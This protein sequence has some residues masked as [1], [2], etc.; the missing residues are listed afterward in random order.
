MC[1]TRRVGIFDAIRAAFVSVGPEL[2]LT[3]LPT[4]S[5]GASS[6]HLFWRLPP[7][8]D[9]VHEVTVDIEISEPP[10]VQRLYFW[11]V[12]TSFAR[13]GTDTGA[14]HLGLQ[15]HP[16]H[17]GAGAVNWGGYLSPTIGRSGE[18][19]GSPLSIPSALDNPN[20][21]DFAW[22]P[23][24]PYRYRIARVEDGVWA[25]SI[26]D[27][28][29]D[30]EVVIRNLFCPGDRLRDMVVWTEAFCA[31]DDPPTTVTWSSPQARLASGD[32]VEPDGYLVNYQA[33]ADGGCSTSN[34]EAIVGGVV[35]RTGV[36][37]S[38]PAG[39]IL[40]PG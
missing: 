15:H 36:S 6:H 12:Q 31:C 9:P 25:G 7:T 24:R 18:L 19:D 2:R 39:S 32:R 11:A 16:A 1:F 21:G 17:P 22:R 10:T 37:R 30:S 5:N 27:L 14:G 33:V 26:T 13:G 20:T 8:T 35:Q 28:I 23:K 34:S 3:G 4:S 29:D 40:R 38:T